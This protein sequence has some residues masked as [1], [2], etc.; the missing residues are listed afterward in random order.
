MASDEGLREA[1][2]TAVGTAYHPVSTAR[3]GPDGDAG[4]VVDQYCRVRGIDDLRVA[5]ASVMPAI[6]RANTNLPCIM[7]GERVAEWMRDAQ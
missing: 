2:K 3:M 1:A 6:P 7:I 4:A 5:D